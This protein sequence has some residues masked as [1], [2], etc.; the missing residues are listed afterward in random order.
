GGKR[1]GPLRVRTV[2]ESFRI[3]AAI[4]RNRE[5]IVSAV[6]TRC[7]QHS[8]SVVCEEAEDVVVAERQLGQRT[9]LATAHPDILRSAVANG[10]RDESAIGRQRGEKIPPRLE[11]NRGFRTVAPDPHQTPEITGGRQI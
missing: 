6:L 8:L 11:L 7:E 2:G 1:S 10:R 5:N 3:P 4:C 9:A